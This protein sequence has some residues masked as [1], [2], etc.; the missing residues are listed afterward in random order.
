MITTLKG[1]LGR[2]YVCSH[3]FKPYDQA[4]KHHCKIK[5]QCRCCLQQDCPDFHYAYPR[6]LK[7]TQRCHDCGRDFFGD[8][9]FEAHRSKTH[10]GKTAEVWQG[11]ICF[12]RRRCVGC[13]KLEVG[14]KHIE[15]H[16]CGYLD[17][18]SCHEYVNAQSH[19]CF[20]QKSLSPQEMKKQKKERKRKR[21]KQQGG[22]PA[23]RGAAAGLQTLR[24]N[25][26]GDDESDDEEEPPP[27]LHVFFDIEAMQPQEQHVANLVVGETEEDPRPVRF[28][29]EHCLRDFLEW[30]DTLTQEDT[31]PVNV[32]AHNFQG[33]DGYFVVNQYHSDNQ[34]VNQ[35]RNGCKL[36]EAKHDKIRV[37]D[38]LSFFQMPLAAFPKTFGLTE[39]KKGYFPHKFNIPDHQEYVGP[40]PA[41]D[42]YMPE[43]MSPEGRQKFE[44]WHKEQR[45]NQVLFDFQKELVAYCESDVRLLKEGC[46]TF[47][48][49]FEAKTGFNPFD[50]MTIASACNRDLRMN[51]MIPNSLASEPVG[52][53]RNKINQS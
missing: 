5:I 46:L 31:R 35:I 19:R 23:K 24:A 21:Q 50:H 12:N 25:E 48:R 41:M 40:V 13:L 15:R 52:G 43:V 2:S 45:D 26:G 47:K 1:F 17:C 36:L 4:G 29:G 38:S 9:C 3:C 27:P 16:R 10:E 51:R 30:L 18:P 22:P 53:W 32:L 11:S 42:H 20:I 6:G 44:T 34:T 14:F 7:A 39:L 28:Q 33:Y 49:L 8:T 37:I